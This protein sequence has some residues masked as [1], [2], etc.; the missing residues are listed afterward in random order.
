MAYVERRQYERK[1]GW[2]VQR[3]GSVKGREGGICREKAV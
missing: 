3:E 1:G 2:H